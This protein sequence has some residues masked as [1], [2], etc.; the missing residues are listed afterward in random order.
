M[1]DNN[2]PS[3]TF[4]HLRHKPKL[5]LRE[6]RLVALEVSAK[7]RHQQTLDSTTYLAPLFVNLLKA[8]ILRIWS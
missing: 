3:A 4:R 1:K 6:R 7:L 5:N 2:A 8:A